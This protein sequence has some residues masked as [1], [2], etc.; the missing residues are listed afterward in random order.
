VR[1]ELTTVSETLCASITMDGLIAREEF[2]ALSSAACS[3][4]TSGCVFSYNETPTHT[5]TQN[6][7][8]YN[9]VYFNFQAFRLLM[10]DTA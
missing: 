4:I 2:I 6:K 8:S 9:F 7:Q 3:R 1:M 10:G 5:Y